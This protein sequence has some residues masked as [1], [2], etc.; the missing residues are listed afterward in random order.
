[1][2]KYLVKGAVYDMDGRTFSSTFLD[3]TYSIETAT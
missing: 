1:M 2:I 3:W